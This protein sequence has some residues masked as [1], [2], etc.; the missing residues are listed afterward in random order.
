MKAWYYSKVGSRPG[1]GLSQYMPAKSVKHGT[2]IFCLDAW[3]P[4]FTF[5]H[6]SPRTFKSP[7]TFRNISDAIVY[8]LPAIAFLV[9][10]Y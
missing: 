9:V 1:A 3:C 6:Q 5:I 7:R 2:K 8:I 10:V 4:L